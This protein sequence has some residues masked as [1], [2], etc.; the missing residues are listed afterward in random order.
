MVFQK[1]LSAAM[2]GVFHLS[3]QAW[4]ELPAKATQQLE[5]CS[6]LV[7]ICQ[8]YMLWYLSPL[9]RKQGLYLLL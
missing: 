3:S 9:I 4:T 5:V 1:D 7:H 8:L 2:Q 6:L